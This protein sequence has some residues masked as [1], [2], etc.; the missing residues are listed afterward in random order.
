M[1]NLIETV[2]RPENDWESSVEAV[3]PLASRKSL[4]F[5]VGPKAEAPVLNPVRKYEKLCAG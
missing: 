3:G 1:H 5:L 4:V 2:P